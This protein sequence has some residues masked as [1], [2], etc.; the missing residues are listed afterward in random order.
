[1]SDQRN[2]SSAPAKGAGPETP[3]RP[4]LRGDDKVAILVIVFAIIVFWV[5]TSFDDVPKALTQGVPPESYP[6]LL[7]G[8]LIFLAVVLFFETRTRPEKKRKKPPAMVYYTA[9]ALIVA[10]LS[11]EWL[12]IVGAMVITC[13]VIP[14]LWGDRRSKVVGLFVV[15]LPLAVYQLFHG[16]LEVQFPL[17]IFQNM[18]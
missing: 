1:M 11:I 2:P 10:T 12:G 5:A 3:A 16:I 13:L 9:A 17:G 6:Q 14:F 18:F 7:A 15:L 4:R 8:L